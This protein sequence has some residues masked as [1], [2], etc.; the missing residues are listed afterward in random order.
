MLSFPLTIT[1]FGLWDAR[2]R[3]SISGNMS[4]PLCGFS[5]SRRF[6]NGPTPA[7]RRIGLPSIPPAQVCGSANTLL[8]AHAGVCFSEK[9]EL[10]VHSCR[11]PMIRSRNLCSLGQIFDLPSLLM[12]ATYD[13]GRNTIS[14]SNTIQE[15]S[16]PTWREP[17]YSRSLACSGDHR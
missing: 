16:R 12:P 1:N 7:T 15:C 9:H 17:R 13:P 8:H 14:E 11:H 2:E 10:V 3:P 5:D 4:P 6:G